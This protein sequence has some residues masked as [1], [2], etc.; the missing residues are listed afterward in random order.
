[1]KLS[2]KALQLMYGSKQQKHKVK[3]HRNVFMWQQGYHFRRILFF[4]FLTLTKLHQPQ[5]AE[6][7][8]TLPFQKKLLALFSWVLVSSTVLLSLVSQSKHWLGYGDQDSTGPGQ[9]QWAMDG[10]ISSP[11]CWGRGCSYLM[12]LLL[13]LQARLSTCKLKLQAIFV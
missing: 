3:Q 10:G 12:P 2:A 13:A 9:L 1:M 8:S 5:R 11:V 4:F 7:D 6:N